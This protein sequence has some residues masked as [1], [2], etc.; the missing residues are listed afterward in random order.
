M[1]YMAAET[2]N[3]EELAAKARADLA[4]ATD[5]AALEAWRVAHLGRKGALTRS[6]TFEVRTGRA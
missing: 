3:L 4:A 6:P 1:R 2:I 5:E